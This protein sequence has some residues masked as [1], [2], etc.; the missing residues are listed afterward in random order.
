MQFEFG[1]SLEC[2][3]LLALC[4]YC[5]SSFSSDYSATTD[6]L[7]PTPKAKVDATLLDLG[8]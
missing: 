5:L 2:A 6:T 3:N 8:K 7:G 4:Y 1:I